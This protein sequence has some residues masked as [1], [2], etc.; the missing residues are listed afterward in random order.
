M[1][2]PLS[3]AVS[4]RRQPRTYRSEYRMHRHDGEWRW[5]IGLD[6]DLRA[7]GAFKASGLGHRHH[8]PQADGGGPQRNGV[9]RLAVETTELGLWTLTSRRVRWSGTST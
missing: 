1:T 9:L 8:R 7:D 2:A 3:A 4:G 6:T 5:V